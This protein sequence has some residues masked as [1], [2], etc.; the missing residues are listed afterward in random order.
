M[1]RMENRER[2]SLLGDESARN[3]LQVDLATSYAK[4]A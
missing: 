1:Q 3:K 4:D 2:R